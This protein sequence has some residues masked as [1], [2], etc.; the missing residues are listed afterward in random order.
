MAIW[1]KT[2]GD[3]FKTDENGY[4][5]YGVKMGR[6]QGENE[7]NWFNGLCKETET[8]PIARDQIFSLWHYL[9]HQAV[10]AR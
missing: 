10:P 8:D 5:A 4:N 1:E 6:F 3:I 7:Y 9:N 2:T